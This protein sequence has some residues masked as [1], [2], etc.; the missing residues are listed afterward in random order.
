MHQGQEKTCTYTDEIFVK[1]LNDLCDIIYCFRF[2][3]LGNPNAK[4][5]SREDVIESRVSSEN[6]GG[7]V[8]TFLLNEFSIAI[9]R[10]KSY[11]IICR[12]KQKF[13]ERCILIKSHNRLVQI[14]HKKHGIKLVVGIK[15]ELFY[16]YIKVIHI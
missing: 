3:I 5:S 11:F 7:S 16:F 8:V 15:K 10:N 4:R 9:I 13:R 14:D 6:K 2:L 12:I 1:R